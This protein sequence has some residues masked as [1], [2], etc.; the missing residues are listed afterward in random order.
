MTTIQAA[1]PAGKL[2]DGHE[3]PA[4][5]FQPI[6]F[7]YTYLHEAI[8]HELALLSQSLQLLLAGTSTG[9]PE[10]RRRYIFLRDVYKYHSAAEDEVIYPALELEVANVTPSYSV[11][12]E[13]EEHLLEEMVDLLLATEQ[14]P[15]KENLL[16]VR[17]LSWRIQTT[18]T[19]HLAKEEAQLLPLLLTHIP[20]REQ[21]GLVAQFL[22]CIPIST[23]ARVLAWVKP[24]AAPADR[25]AIREALAGA[26]DDPLLCSLLL[27]WLEADE[28]DGAGSDGLARP[29]SP[30]SPGSSGD[31]EAAAA[32]RSEALRFDELQRLLGEVASCARRRCSRSGIASADLVA[33]ADALAAAMAGHMEAEERGVLPALERLC[34]RPEQRALLWAMVRAMPLRL[35]E[36]FHNALRKELAELEATIATCQQRLETA[37]ELA[38]TTEVMQRLAARFQ[39]LRGIYRAHS[40][41][42]DE[43]VFPALEG[44]KVLR[45]VS[46]AYTLDH[47]QEEMQFQTCS[48]CLDRVMATGTLDSRRQRLAELACYYSG[49]RGS[50]ETHIRAEELELWPLF[51]EHFPVAEQEHLVGLIIGRTG[52]DVLTSLLS[53]VRGAMTREEEDA[54]MLSIRSAASSTAFDAARRYHDPKK[55]VLGCRHYRRAAQLVAPCCDRAYVCRFCHDEATD[56][57]L[58]R[59]AVCEMVCMECSLRQPVA[60]SC[61]GCGTCMSRYYCKVC[62]LFDDDPGKAIYHCPFCNFCRQGKGPGIDSFHCMSCNACMSLELFNKHV[63]KEQSL[64]RDCPVCSDMLFESKHPVK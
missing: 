31:D 32:A 46:H 18:V 1:R 45:N 8:R 48:E 15:T 2:A 29:G 52:A 14:S 36:R 41:S 58:D 20:P 7:L 61:S 42:E 40:L 38:D 37:A 59:Y 55:G 25:A 30:S 43:V 5:V 9:W 44:K 27:G 34:P 63:C 24:H 22:C 23:V 51:A 26:V 64:K 4:T 49:V 47:E 6:H 62:H 13:D 33:S 11:E 57:V 35:L 12:H 60:G 21:G 50:L 39:F 3:Q 19:K 28:A 56:H 54:M 17:Q 16:A 53:W 10:L